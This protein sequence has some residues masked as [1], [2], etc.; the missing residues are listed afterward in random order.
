[1][2][3]DYL[4]QLRRAL[5]FWPKA[6]LLAETED[7]LRSA[8]TDVGEEEAIRRFGAPAEIARSFRAR[9]GWLYAGVALAGALA[10]PVL[11]YPIVENSLPPAP[12]P[13]DRPPDYLH[14]QQDKVAQLFLLG[15]A[16]GLVAAA[17]WRRGGRIRMAAC[18]V[19]ALALVGMAALGAVL[20]VQWADAVPGTPA[21]LSS[22]WLGQCLLAVLAA[23]LTGRAALLSRA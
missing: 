17:T 9:L 15:V 18:V 12:W 8:A 21:W 2:I 20:S 22:V 4:R 6:R 13:G 11:S 3:E 16:A 1:M 7:H 23:V 5:G 10:F 14:W 19:A